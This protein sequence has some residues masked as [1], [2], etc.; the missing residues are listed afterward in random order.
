LIFLSLNFQKKIEILNKFFSE[1]TASSINLNLKNYINPSQNFFLMLGITF[2][3]LSTIGYSINQI[4]NKK[5]TYHVDTWNVMVLTGAIITLTLGIGTYFFGDF[6]HDISLGVILFTLIAGF[7]GFIALYA[8]LKSFSKLN[9][10]EALAIG[11]A[12]PFLILIMAWLTMGE[13]LNFLELMGML[14]IF[15]GI[16]L[17]IKEKGKFEWTKYIYLPFITLLGWA[18]YNFAIGYL[19]NQGIS[20]FNVAFYLEFL[21]FFFSLLYLII[22]SDLSISP[23]IFKPN[24]FSLG[25]LSGISTSAGTLFFAFATSYIETAIVGSIV[26]SQVIFAGLLGYLF[27]NEKLT[28]AQIIGVGIVFIGLALI[29]LF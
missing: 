25:L 4:F 27:L 19:V 23:K 18:V 6:S 3:L 17:V 16:L 8:L 12:Y 7:A 15:L 28:K 24:L 13:T 20:M 21:V 9:I 11:N 10:G 22:K 29:E 5:L 14:S 1:T 2:A 26:S